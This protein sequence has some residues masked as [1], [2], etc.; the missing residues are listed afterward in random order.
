MRP[1]VWVSLCLI[2]GIA[3][4]ALS[5]SSCGSSDKAKIRLVNAMPTQLSGL[6]MLID[7]NSIV[8]SVG[9][10]TASSYASVSSGSRHVQI[11][12]TGTSSPI[13][14]T[15]TSVSSG[16]NTTALAYLGVSN[17]VS[18]AFL[19]DN[20]SAPSSGNFNIRVIN[21]SPAMGSAGADVYIVPSGT[22]ITGVSPTISASSPGT[23]DNGQ[24]SAYISL[25]AGDYDVIFTSPGQKNPLA[26]SGQ[27]SFSAG[28]VRTAIGLNS[29]FGG[30]TVT[31]F[32][33][34]G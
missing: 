11:E 31:V 29:Q 19:A 23:R 9:Y 32:S 18:S 16:S 3:G 4:L 7:G 8:S 6:D 20:N 24:A 30:F 22:S 34:A 25:A 33:D 2:L 13:I 27:I 26:D 1:R 14:D 5:A 10:A 17:N 21:A 12:P 28:Q 15:N